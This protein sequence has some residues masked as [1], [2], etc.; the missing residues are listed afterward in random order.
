MAIGN[1]KYTPLAGHFPP[2]TSKWNKVEHH[3]FC[4]LS[5]NGRGRTLLNHEVIVNLI[6]N[7]TTDKGLS[8]QAEIDKNSYPKGIKIS[9]QQ[10]KEINLCQAKFHGADWNYSVNPR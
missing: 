4:H 1:N 7:T 5:E 8:V 9:D 6:A 3:L 2:G 10:M